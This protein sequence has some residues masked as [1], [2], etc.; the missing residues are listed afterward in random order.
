LI[1]A[2]S[3]SEV[4]IWSRAE[5]GAWSRRIVGGR[6]AAAD[7]PSL[8]ITLPLAKVDDGPRSMTA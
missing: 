5:K 2:L 8:G 3:A 6:D 7:M 4:I 1:D